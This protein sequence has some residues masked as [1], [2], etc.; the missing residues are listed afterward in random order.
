MV[1]IHISLGFNMP[2]LSDIFNSNHMPEISDFFSLWI[3]LSVWPLQYCCCSLVLG[4]CPNLSKEGSAFS[5]RSCFSN[6]MV[7]SCCSNNYPRVM[8]VFK[9]QKYSVQICWKRRPIILMRTEYLV[10][11]AK[12]PFTRECYLMGVLLQLRSLQ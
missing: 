1:A 12:A 5:W 3:Q 9:R 6:G 2:E 4:G 7:V 11:A 8:V 10:M